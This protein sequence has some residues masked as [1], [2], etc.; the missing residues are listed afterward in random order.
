MTTT[1]QTTNRPGSVS[2]STAGCWVLDIPEP[3]A[4]SLPFHGLN[5]NA[6]LREAA[7]HG[8]DHDRPPPQVKQLDKPCHLVVCGCGYVYDVDETM[9]EHFADPDDAHR[10][11]IAAG[12]TSDLRC[13]E[14]RGATPAGALEAE[15]TR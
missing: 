9:E 2:P 10:V 3:L 14:C 6:A 5:E 11:V 8:R 7:A 15:G 13:T 4:G 1:D 12:W